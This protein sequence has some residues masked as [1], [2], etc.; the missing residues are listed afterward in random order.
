M[1][2]SWHWLSKHTS[3]AAEAHL[4]SN[5]MSA[6]K[7]C[8]TTYE[9]LKAGAGAAVAKGNKVTV[10]ATGTVKETQKK[11]WCVSFYL[12]VTSLVAKAFNT[13]PER[14][15]RHIVPE[16]CGTPNRMKGGVLASGAG[17]LSEII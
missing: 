11:F 12:G 6:I 8:K 14:N 1:C 2:G 10:H 15:G 9:I 17:L 7:G 3:A 13:F 5:V 4:R 16:K